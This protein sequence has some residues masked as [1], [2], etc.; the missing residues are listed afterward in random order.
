VETKNGSLNV[1]SYSF[2][3]ADISARAIADAI[4]N[5][6]ADPDELGMKDDFPMFG[7]ITGESSQT[8]EKQILKSF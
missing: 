8:L 5:E 4:L 3:P 1:I 6:G 7:K 2:L